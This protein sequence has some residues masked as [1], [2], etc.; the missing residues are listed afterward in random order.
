MARV[1]EKQSAVVAHQIKYYRVKSVLDI[2][3][4]A[5]EVGVGDSRGRDLFVRW[6]SRNEGDAHPK[7]INI[8]CTNFI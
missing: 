8:R 2:V 6:D 4:A 5:G 3:V 7:H 1:F